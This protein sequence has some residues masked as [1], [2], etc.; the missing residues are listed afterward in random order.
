MSTVH[1]CNVMLKHPSLQICPVSTC[2]MYELARQS[3]IQSFP[4]STKP[5]PD[6]GPD[7]GPDR[8]P[9]HGPDRGPDRGPD[10]EPDHGSDHRR[11]KLKKKI[12]RL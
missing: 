8:G 5:G 6:H 3:R 1:C 12:N 7:H 11:K 9:D 4:A 2:Q 10:H